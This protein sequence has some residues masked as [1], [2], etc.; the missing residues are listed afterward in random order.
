MSS[1]TTHSHSLMTLFILTLNPKKFY[2]ENNLSQIASTNVNYTFYS[3]L[4]TLQ[5][6]MESYSL[7]SV[8]LLSMFP[9]FNYKTQT[10][11]NL[12][13]RFIINSLCMC[14]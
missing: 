8:C 2:V 10:K 13:L 14:T 5:M 9:S 3:F 1:D 4:K 12:K 6:V 7:L 11:R